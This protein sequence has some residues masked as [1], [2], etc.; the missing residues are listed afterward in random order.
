M[1]INGFKQVNDTLGHGCGDKL[2]Q[3][4]AHRLTT[5]IRESD[6]VARFGGDEFAVLMPDLA[7]RDDVN[8]VLKKILALFDT[9]FMLDDT[10]VTSSASI[11]ISLFP[12]DGANGE[13]LIKNA[14]KAMYE[15]KES[16]TCS[17]MF[18]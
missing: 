17:Y 13:E 2:L 3:E 9:P 10:A 11:G 5:S 15:A 14:D 16:S 1:D 7:S 18:S 12:D 6:T 8:I 4:V